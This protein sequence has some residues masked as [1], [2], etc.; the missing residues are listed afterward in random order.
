MLN[1]KR[2]NVLLTV[3]SA[4]FCFGCAIGQTIKYHGITLDIKSSG[5]NSIAVA[6]LDNRPYVMSGE[7]D[8]SYIGTF[9]GGYGNPFDVSTESENALAADMTVVLC[10]S[11]NNHGYQAAPLPPVK[12]EKKEQATERLIQS[13]SDR[14]LLLTI[15][16][17]YSN[18]Y[19]NTG[20]FYDVH[21]AVIDKSGKVLAESTVKGEDDLGGSFWNPP[22]HAKEK[23]PEVYKQKLESL[24]NDDSV[25]SALK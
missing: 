2:M 16:E 11:L 25:S 6:A 24:I 17:W 1:T 14:L 23:V 4:L 10:E 20:L 3:L 22:A 13:N 15:N 5:T 21:L 12:G 8:M 7:K 9:R 18:T 19:Q